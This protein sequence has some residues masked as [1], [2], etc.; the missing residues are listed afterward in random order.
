MRILNRRKQYSFGLILRWSGGLKAKTGIGMLRSQ[1]R[2]RSR[3]C[4]SIKNRMDGTVD[5]SVSRSKTC[6]YMSM[7][8]ILKRRKLCSRSDG[9]IRHLMKECKIKMVDM[10]RRQCIFVLFFYEMGRQNW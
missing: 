10:N 9:F 2:G 4:T 1:G 3:L 8:R 7:L 6:R 5:D